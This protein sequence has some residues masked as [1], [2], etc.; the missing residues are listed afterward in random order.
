M[1]KKTLKAL[2]PSGPSYQRNKSLR[3]RGV[4]G[5]AAPSSMYHTLQYNVRLKNTS[6]GG[7]R[8]SGN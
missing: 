7:C 8:R 3:R 1:E 5:G 6:F 4:T 2:L